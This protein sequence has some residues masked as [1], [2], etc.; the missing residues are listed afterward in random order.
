MSFKNFV[1]EYK[2]AIDETVYTATHES[3]LKVIL[4][5]KKGF[6]KSYAT[7]STKY[8]SVNTG[9][10]VPGE[11]EVTKVI[12]GVAHFL[13][14]KVFEQPDGTNAF[15]EFSKYGASAN[16][17]TSFGV[18]NYLFSCTDYFFEN[19]EILLNFVQTPY[20][21]T[22]NVEK[23]KG[24][25]A[26]EI[27][28]YEDDAE[29][30]CFYNCLAG[31]YQNHPVKTKI[32]GSVEEIMKTTPSLLYKCYNTFYHPSNMA[33]IC[34]GDID[35][36]KLLKV[37]DKCI[38]ADKPNEK[39]TQV[40]PKEPEAVVKETTKAE[41]D[42]PVPMFM[43]GFKDRFTGG[44]GKELLEREILSQCI[45]QTLFGASSPFY[46][47]LYEKGIINST[48]SA[49]YEYE[50]S[51]AYAMFMGE[52]KEVLKI[53][54]EIYNTIEKTAKNGL[55]EDSFERAKRMIYGKFLSLLDS[56]ENTGNEYMFSYHRGV[57]LFDY[58]EVCRKITTEAAMKRLKEL[59]V[60]E[61][62]SLSVVNPKKEGRE[63]E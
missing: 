41:F 32:A 62:S 38:K 34:V 14:H 52:S 35:E 22:E 20:F 24:I 57:D 9:F 18:T 12:D 8:G 33:V 54:E 25:I 7:F 1:K 10:I 13:E 16:A 55:D 15:A 29:Q 56:V 53:R 17:F 26:Q 61:Y 50:D 2:E 43:L 48:F 63:N 45:L 36:N 59:F 40:F 6:K 31:M 5:K 23:E 58:P 60:K 11:T 51:C 46:T 39:I 19:L 47:T 44:S 42:I 37:V 30:T 27:K 49:S 28:M 21:T 3:G 4:I